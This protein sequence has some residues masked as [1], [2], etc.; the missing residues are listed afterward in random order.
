MS[1]NCNYSGETFECLDPDIV[2]KCPFYFPVLENNFILIKP[3][4]QSPLFL[5]T[6]FFSIVAPLL[7]FIVY[8]MLMLTRPIV[9]KIL[10]YKSKE[11]C[12]KRHRSAGVSDNP[13]DF[14]LSPQIQKIIISLQRVIIV[15]ASEICC[16]LTIDSQLNRPIHCCSLMILNTLTF[17]I[18]YEIGLIRSYK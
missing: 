1:T 16:Y 11:A 17:L 10:A 13:I 8:K 4:L 7:D 18:T 14:F 15:Y 3:L 2:Q 9:I 5:K 6:H 12:G